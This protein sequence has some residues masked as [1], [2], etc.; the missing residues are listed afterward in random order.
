MNI[1]PI[2]EDFD[3]DF[4]HPNISIDL[5]PLIQKGYF[6]K[7]SKNLLKEVWDSNKTNI[8]ARAVYEYTFDDNGLVDKFY[9]KN[10]I[11]YVIEEFK[12]Y[13]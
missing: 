10:G 2:V 8:L 9:W 1:N 7:L 12:F 3:V 4:A 5:L 11:N 6:G 13:Y